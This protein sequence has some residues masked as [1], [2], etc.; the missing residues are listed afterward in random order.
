MWPRALCGNFFLSR[1]WKANAETEETLLS[2]A[3]TGKFK[4]A[5]L[6]NKG[7]MG[8]TVR[9]GELLF[10]QNRNTQIVYGTG[11]H[12]FVTSITKAVR[13]PI[14]YNENLFIKEG[15]VTIVTL[16][17]NQIAIAQ[18]N[19]RPVILLPGRHAYHDANFSLEE[20]D[21]CTIKDL[22]TFSKKNIN[23]LQI[24]EWEIG[25]VLRISHSHF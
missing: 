5:K 20:K 17:P 14:D 2:N 9:P 25:M 16:N 4:N 24:G 8:V 21:I 7:T 3:N 18:F 6:T 13:K 11:V 23:L 12:S 19:H 1:I 10:C 22:S 15:V